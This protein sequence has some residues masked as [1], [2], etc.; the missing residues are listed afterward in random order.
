[1]TNS[2]KKLAIS[3]LENLLGGIEDNLGRARAALVPGRGDE[4]YGYSPQTLNQII[5]A[6]EEKGREIRD[7]IK[8]LQEAT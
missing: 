8:G 5:D 2:T 1:M 7:A 4:P 3:A 6:Y